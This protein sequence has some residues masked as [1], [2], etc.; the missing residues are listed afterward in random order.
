MGKNQNQIS[1]SPSVR[2]PSAAGQQPHRS[3]KC[4]LVFPSSLLFHESP[5][6][7]PWCPAPASRHHG[8]ALSDCLHADGCGDYA[9]HL[10][11]R[12]PDRLVLS[13]SLSELQRKNVPRVLKRKEKHVYFP[14][15]LSLS[16]QYFASTMVIV[17]MSV[18]ATV[19]V[20]QFHHHNPNNGQMPRLV[21]V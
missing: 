10:R 15:S 14:T 11:L 19:I 3:T 1:I 12:S 2:D 16:G 6:P 20:L 9:C 5:Y 13:L 18:V 7:L 21:R 8:S 17:G 4:A